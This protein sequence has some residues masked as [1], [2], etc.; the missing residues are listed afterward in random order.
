MENIKLHRYDAK[1]PINIY[2]D[3]AK[4]AGLGYVLTQPDESSKKE[5]ILY[6]GSTGLTDA[7]KRWAMC[8]IEM[9]AV[10]YSLINAKHLT[11][12]ANDI[13]IY[14]DHQPLIGVSKKCFDDIDNPRLAKMFELIAHYNF[15][16]THIP[17]KENVPAD[18]LSR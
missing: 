4:T 18:V 2:C 16:L 11:Y 7:Q 17:G 15:D 12:G 5:Y 1:L 9:A 6:C 3:A 13:R 14:T 10:V 8:E